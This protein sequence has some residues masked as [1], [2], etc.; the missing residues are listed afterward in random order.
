MTI[1]QITNNKYL[2]DIL[3]FLYENNFK[4][5]AIKYMSKLTNDTYITRFQE[6]IGSIDKT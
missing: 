5:Q 2:F 1:S 4:T 3:K 6:F